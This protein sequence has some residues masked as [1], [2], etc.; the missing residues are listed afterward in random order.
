MAQIFRELSNWLLNFNHLAHF[1]QI[2]LLPSVRRS[3]VGVALRFSLGRGP[4]NHE[5]AS[6]FGFLCTSLVCPT[7]KDF[8]LLILLLLAVIL[9]VGLWH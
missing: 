8:V 1:L 9:T 5:E 7:R 6:G 2:F 4:L 3:T